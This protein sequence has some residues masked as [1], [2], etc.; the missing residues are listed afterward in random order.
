MLV[1]AGDLEKVEEICCSGADGYNVL[2]F[3]RDGVGERGDFEVAR[4]LCYVS[5]C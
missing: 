4:T 3:R 2:V 1:F 5:K